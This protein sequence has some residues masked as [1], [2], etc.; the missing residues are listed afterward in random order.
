MPR[1]SL[2]RLT[3]LICILLSLSCTLQ[4]QTGPTGAYRISGKVVDAH[5][6]AALARCSVQIDDVK[7]RSAS[8][9]VITGE[10]GQF[11]FASVALGKYSLTA[12]R[13]GY[14]TQSF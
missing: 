1:L 9:T 11:A 4:A 6:G 10:D 2:S 12:A 3:I 7:S 14:L 13:R 8:R 5:T